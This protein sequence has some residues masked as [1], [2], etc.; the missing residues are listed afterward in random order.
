MD[1]DVIVIGGSFA[2]LSAAQALGRARRRV[3]V[4]DGG[5]P[6]NRTSAAAHNV[7]GHDGKPP[8]QL[9]AERRAETIQPCGDGLRGPRYGGFDG[10]CVG[11]GKAASG[12][13]V[14]QGLVENEVD[15]IADPERVEHERHRRRGGHVV[16][17]VDHE[18]RLQ[19]VEGRN[20]GNLGLLAGDHMQIRQMQ[21][22]KFRLTAQRAL[23]QEGERIFLELE[24][25]Q[26]AIAPCRGAQAGSGEAAKNT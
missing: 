21:Q 24:F 9:L 13:E 17:R 6:R 10:L 2:G 7:L 19:G 4:I 25:G 8:A 11:G 1:Y 12:F 14:A 23:G 20:P 18:V 26:F 5:Q 3:L 22:P 16:P 15:K